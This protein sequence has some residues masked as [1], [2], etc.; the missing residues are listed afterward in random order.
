MS[1][2]TGI[3]A[4]ILLTGCN[5][6]PSETK[7]LSTDTV[8]VVKDTATAVAEIPADSAHITGQTSV[9]NT[10]ATERIQLVQ[11]AKTLSGVPYKY[12]SSDPS[13]GFDCS[14]FIT[15]VF[16]HFNITV[17]RSSVDFTNVGKEIKPAEA[18]AG[19]LIL[20]TGTDSLVRIVGH[21]GIIIENTDSL[22]FIHS[23]SGKANGVT[24]TALNNYYQ[25]RFVKV[26]DIF[27]K[28]NS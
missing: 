27:G 19:D 26:I 6:M 24:I 20:F 13:Q 14:G 8:V 3:F 5:G 1:I 28:R 25:G 9:I 2:K 23:T 15:Y 10:G 11:Y 17:P 4:L 18:V 22:R 12:A 7:P 21:M 16:N